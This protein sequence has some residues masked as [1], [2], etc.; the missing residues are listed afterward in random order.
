MAVKIKVI[1]TKKFKKCNVC[2]EFKNVHEFYKAK[3]GKFGV[4]ATCK[5][6]ISEKRKQKYHSDEKY[7]EKRIQQAKQY[8]QD[9]KEQVKEYVKQWMRERP[10]YVNR[11]VKKWQQENREYYRR[12]IREYHKNFK[13]K[14]NIN[15]KG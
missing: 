1:N 4:M 8:Y 12:Y 11:Y 9:H 10:D 7:R 2:K 14:D 13:K 15:R 5:K 3:Q 6:C